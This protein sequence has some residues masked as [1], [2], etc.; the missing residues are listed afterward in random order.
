MTGP[1]VIQ[2]LDQTID[3]YRTLGIQQQAATEPSDMLILY[4]N[5]QTANQVIALAFDIARANAEIL[6]KQPG[7]RAPPR[8]LLRKPES[9]A[10]KF[11]AQGVTVQS[12]LDS[13]QRQLEQRGRTTKPTLQAKISELRA[14][15]I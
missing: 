7:Q 12:E 13:D 14:N 1:Q 3:W 9:A 6:A 15:S 5:R 10:G 11:S 2:L 8:A 4:D